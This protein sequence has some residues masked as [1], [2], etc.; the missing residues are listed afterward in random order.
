MCHKSDYYSDSSCCLEVRWRLSRPTEMHDD[1]HQ[2]ARPVTDVSAIEVVSYGKAIQS[3]VLRLGSCTPAIAIMLWDCRSR[4]G[5]PS[6]ISNHATNLM[7]LAQDHDLHHVD[8]S[9]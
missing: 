1:I 5:A 2:S 7:P 3:T 8:L 9:L 6:V 4:V